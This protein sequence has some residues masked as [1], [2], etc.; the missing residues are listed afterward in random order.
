MDIIGIKLQ[1]GD[2]II[3]KME[4]QPVTSDVTNMKAEDFFNNTPTQRTSNLVQERIT[5]SQPYLLHLQHNPSSGVSLALS[6]WLLSCKKPSVTIEYKDVLCV[7]S[8]DEI[9]QRAYLEQTSSITL[10]S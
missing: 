7:F 8:P 10:L 9:V 5:I 6:P 2:E 3:A 4:S 1:N